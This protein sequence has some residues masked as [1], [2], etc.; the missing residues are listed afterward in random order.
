MI[1]ARILHEN[2]K[3][4]QEEQAIEKILFNKLN[5]VTL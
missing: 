5:E 3:E 1:L 4:S 2:V